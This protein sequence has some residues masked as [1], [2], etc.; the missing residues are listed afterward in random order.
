MR[1][2]WRSLPFMPIVLRVEQCVAWTAERF[3]NALVGASDQ[4]AAIAA[5]FRLPCRG[6]CENGQGDLVMPAGCDPVASQGFE[7][8]LQGL[9]RGKHHFCRLLP[10]A[11][12]AALLRCPG[13]A[14]PAEGCGDPRKFLL[15]T[16]RYCKLLHAFVYRVC[17]TRSPFVLLFADKFASVVM[18][19]FFQPIIFSATAAVQS[20]KT[21]WSCW[22][23]ELECSL[24][25]SIVRPIAQ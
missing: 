15:V 3:V 9:T 25:N 20:T 11:F 6:S 17:V 16:I 22:T 13:V 5:G 14:Q 8:I 10:D 24:S 1:C 18:N 12:R 7:T 23:E 2:L 19:A 21:N 4:T